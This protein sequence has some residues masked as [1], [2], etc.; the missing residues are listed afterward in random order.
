MHPSDI[1]QWGTSFIRSR[2]VK[3]P[4]GRCSQTNAKRHLEIDSDFESTSERLVEENELF[5]DAVL[6]FRTTCLKVETFVN[7]EENFAYAVCNRFHIPDS[8]FD[9]AYIKVTKHPNSR[10]SRRVVMINGD[11]V[12]AQDM[13][14]LLNGYEVGVAVVDAWFSMLQWHYKRDSVFCLSTKLF[15]ELCKQKK[16]DFFSYDYSAL[17]FPIQ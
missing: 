10:K 7:E 5:L 4:F 17:S 12:T 15:K 3:R 2:G 14:G 11:C 16:G 13:S 9:N 8:E 6:E 1:I